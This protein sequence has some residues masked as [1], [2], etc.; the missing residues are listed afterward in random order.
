MIRSLS[1]GGGG[2]GIPI[3]C[4]STFCCG[5]HFDTRVGINVGVSSSHS[6]SFSFV[7]VV[8]CICNRSHMGGT[9]GVD[10]PSSI[11]PVVPAETQAKGSAF[12]VWLLSGANVHD[13]RSSA[14]ILSDNTLL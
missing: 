14:S 9:G 13:L 11:C 3:S 12:L 7:E 4:S 5:G 2:R 1:P 10:I 8:A 6:F